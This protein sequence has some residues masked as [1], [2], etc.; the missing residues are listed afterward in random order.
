MKNHRNAQFPLIRIVDDDEEVRESLKLM[1]EC[2]GYQV[3]A[4]ESG[5]EFLRDFDSGA[6]GCV[7]LDVRLPG[8]SGPDLQLKLIRDDI[9]LPIIF[10]TSYADI[11]TAI[12]T[13]KTGAEDFLLKPV[14]PEKLL[15]VIKRVVSHNQL[16]HS[17]I[18][19]PE[20]LRGEIARLSEQPRKVLQYM[21]EG[22]TDAMMAERMGLSERTIQVYR[23]SVY[24]A[25][26]V[27]SVKQFGLLADQV[28]EILNG[29][30]ESI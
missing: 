23:A 3:R 15:E 5:E 6:P 22:M 12:D 19:V 24:K 16:L 10:I 21:L 1:L 2:E 9:R 7:L 14:D 26:G 17:G 29:E 30:G 13:L 18:Q 27:H 28:R 8:F 11:Q 25:L 20:N 4:Y